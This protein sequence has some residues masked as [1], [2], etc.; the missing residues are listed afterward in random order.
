MPGRLS[1]SMTTDSSDQPLAALEQ[2]IRRCGKTTNWIR[3]EPINQ[4]II[5]ELGSLEGKGLFEVKSTS[6]D[7][8]KPFPEPALKH[9]DPVP[10]AE[11]SKQQIAV[12]TQQERRDTSQLDLN[13]LNATNLDSLHF[14]IRNCEKCNLCQTRNTVVF[15]QGNQK[16]DIVFIGEGPG[17]DE[18]RSGVAFVG[19]AGKLL[20]QWIH[21]IGLNREAVYICNI[22]KCRPPGNR[23]PNGDEIGACSPFLYKQLELIQPKL[24]VT[25]GNVATKTLLPSAM[26]IMRM[27]GKLVDFN[28][29]PLIP[30]FHPS[31]LLR[32]QSALGNVWN[33]MRQIRQLLHQ[34]VLNSPSKSH[35]QED[36]SL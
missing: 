1:S 32:N 7:P 20:T 13:P 14:R 24:I 28:G 16:A 26:G 6:S 29:T 2:V 10:Q 31:Y 18:D 36:D 23:N 12:P 3:L 19:R 5:D 30:T 8:P 11:N 4:E 15:G 17:E 9:K 35:P 22:V 34:R 27:R 25:M 21:S 33:D